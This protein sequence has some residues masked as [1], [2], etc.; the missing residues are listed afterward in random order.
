VAEVLVE[1]ER[2]RVFY[3]H[4]G[5]GVTLSGGEPLV[6]PGFT[7]ALLR[8][9]R[10]AGLHTAVETS[11]FQSWD[12]LAAVLDELDLL[13]YDL[14]LMDPDAHRRHTGVSNE[15]IL[16]N[17]ERAAAR[18]IP[19]IVRVPVIPGFTDEDS[20]FTAMRR[21]LQGIGP[22][23]RIDLLPYHRLGEA[24]YAR[25]GREYTLRIPLAAE[26]RLEQIAALFRAG[27]FLVQ[28]G[29]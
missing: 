7:S 19:I 23:R 20:N 4:S 21:F 1:A 28:I 8:G 2:D 17:L 26:E 9:C 29:G 13:L 5:G 22:I 10:Q 15:Q 27:G 14:K 3:R 6:Q 24:T 18:G 16:G 11:G 25:M 12:V